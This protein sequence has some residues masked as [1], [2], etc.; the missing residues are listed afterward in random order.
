MRTSGAW[1]AIVRT[2][3]VVSAH[4]NNFVKTMLRVGAQNGH[5]RVVEDQHGSPTGA[6]DLAGAV[7]TIA[8]WLAD[9]PH[10]PTGM[11]HFSNAGL[12]TWADFA[13]EIFSDASARGG[14]A[15]S[16][17][18]IPTSAYPTPAHRPADS[19]LSHA[20]IGAP[21]G[22]APRPWQAALSDI[23][24]ELLGTKA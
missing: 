6:A 18:G 11:F 7:V 23:L 22:I 21:Y 1:H 20:A 15:A 3:W 13:R 10:A 2:A 16:V 14:P 5:L 12:T 4:G 9:D 8:T 19:L 17:E 24:D